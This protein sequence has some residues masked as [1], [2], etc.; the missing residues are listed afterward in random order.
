MAGAKQ[1]EVSP[2][3]VQ[4]ARWRKRVARDVQAM[5]VDIEQELLFVKVLLLQVLDLLFGLGRCAIL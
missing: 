5:F 1:H 2:R 4:A 3:R